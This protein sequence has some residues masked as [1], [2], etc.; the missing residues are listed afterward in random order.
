MAKNEEAGNLQIVSS[1]N[2]MQNIGYPPRRAGE[3][4]ETRRNKKSGIR[5]KTKQ[6]E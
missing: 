4:T 3:D 5:K 1:S 2:E 6:W